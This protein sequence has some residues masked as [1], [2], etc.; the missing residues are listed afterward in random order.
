MQITFFQLCLW[1]VILLIACSCLVRWSDPFLGLALLSSSASSSSRR[2]TTCST[3]LEESDGFICEP[4]EIWQERKLVYRLQDKSN[5]MKKSSSIFFLS[6][7][8][9]NFHCSHARRIGQMG[10]GGKWLC[11]PFRLKT[12]ADC[13]IYSVGSNGEFSF[14]VDM[15]QAMPHC[16]IHTFD[17]NPFKCPRKVCTFHQTQFGNGLVPPTSKTWPTVVDELGHRN[18]TIDVLKID[19]EGGE[20]DLFP[21]LF[22]S[23][24]TS[25][26]RQIL[27]ELHPNT[28]ERIHAF[29]ELLRRNHYVIFNKEPNLIA[30]AKFF[31]YTFL[32]LNKRFFQ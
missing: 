18:R 22:E 31:E 32:R 8:E 30:G 5:L 29:F 11:D 9:P 12:R 1:T 23:P 14:E 2:P 27:V 20:Y 10:D 16:D 19:I 7:W 25:F 15:K 28:D 3:S 13:L 21:I 6:N 4:D 26:P 17:M 24:E